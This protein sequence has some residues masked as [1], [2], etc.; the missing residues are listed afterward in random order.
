[1]VKTKAGNLLSVRKG[2]GHGGFAPPTVFRSDPGIYSFAFLTLKGSSVPS[3]VA[4]VQDVD[5]IMVFKNDGT[6]DF[7]KPRGRGI[8]YQRGVVVHQN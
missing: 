7:G 4:A 5:E 6:C 8:G 3:I 2:D 1:M